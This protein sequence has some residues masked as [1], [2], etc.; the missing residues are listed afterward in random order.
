MILRPLTLLILALAASVASAS[1]L[2]KVVSV[3]VCSDQYVLL[4]ADP[5]QILSLSS[6]SKD[7]KSS[8]MAKQAAEFAQNNGRAEAIAIQQPDLVIAHQFTDPALLNM[9]QEIE[10]DVLQIPTLTALADIPAQVRFVGK[11]LGRDGIAEDIARSFEAE[12]NAYSPVS[13]IAPLAAFFYPNG[14]ALGAGTLSHE[15]LTKGGARNLSA[16]LGLQGGGR[17]SLEQ[18]VLHAPDLLISSPSYGGFS[19]SEEMT[20]HPALA[21]VPV[22]HST[23]DWVCGTPNVLRA[24]A[25]IADSVAAFQ[26]SPPKERP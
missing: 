8:A 10:I 4:L 18:V 22:V 19:R 2:P 20:T 17:L 15:I 21:D 25:Q 12:L 5:S 1:D 16:E 9:L 6:L 23:P 3:N 24:V 7:P 13:G 11:A 14:Y 26:N